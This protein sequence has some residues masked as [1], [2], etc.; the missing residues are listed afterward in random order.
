M[1]TLMC[2]VFGDPFEVDEILSYS[3]NPDTGREVVHTVKGAS[4]IVI[5][6]AIALTIVKQD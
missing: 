3:D 6:P 4:F 5:S 2:S 1:H